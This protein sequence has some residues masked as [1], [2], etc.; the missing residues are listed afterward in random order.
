MV[1]SATKGRNEWAE[2]RSLT[3]HTTHMR[4]LKIV[5]SLLLDKAHKSPMLYSPSCCCPKYKRAPLWAH[6]LLGLTDADCLAPTTTLYYDWLLHETHFQGISKR[7]E[8]K[9]EVGLSTS[10]DLDLLS[11]YSWWRLKWLLVLSVCFSMSEVT[12]GLYVPFKSVPALLL[13]W[14]FSKSYLLS[15]TVSL[16]HFSLSFNFLPPSY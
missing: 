1:T 10:A 14:H 11:L 6:R 2:G 15:Q 5:S 16:Y 13:L 7:K 8:E 4:W 3:T 12:S 9:K